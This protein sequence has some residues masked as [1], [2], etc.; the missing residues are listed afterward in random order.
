MSFAKKLEGYIG[1]KY[2][3]LDLE[4]GFCEKVV[5]QEVN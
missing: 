1:D 5:W 4:R 3:K 2:K